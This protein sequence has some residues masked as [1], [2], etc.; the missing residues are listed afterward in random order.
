MLNNGLIITMKV[1]FDEIVNVS[2][3]GAR[4]NP[5]SMNDLLT[6]ANNLCS[7]SSITDNERILLLVIDFQ[8]DIMENGS[9]GVPNSH[10][11][12]KNL[13]NWMYTNFEKISDIAISIDTHQPF[14]I[15]HPAWWVDEQGNHPKPFT[16]ITKKDIDNNKWKAVI[17]P[18]HSYE[19]VEGLENKGKKQLVIWPYHC[20]QGTFGHAIENQFSNMVYFHSVARKTIPM[21]IVKGQD[22]LSEIYW[23]ITAEF[24]PKNR[25]NIEFLNA[26]TN[27]D[28]IIIAGEAKSH[29]VLETIKQIIELL[30]MTDKA[31]SGQIDISEELKKVYILEDCMSTIPG[32]EQV[33]EDDFEGFKN[34]YNLNVVKS[35]NFTL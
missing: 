1:K 10:N 5:L 18:K 13:L 14:Q 24:D 33:T 6:K 19:Y 32:F 2:K 12:V 26:L 7:K 15:F 34:T 11:D 3:I 9:L 21:R 4:D 28:K 20:L 35:T 16:I 8:N 23:I 27:Y 25:I 29:C 17:D 31:Q 30:K 22:P